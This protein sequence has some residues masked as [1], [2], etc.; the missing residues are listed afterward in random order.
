[1]QPS[2]QTEL[3]G[4]LATLCQYESM[5]GPYHPQTLCLLTQ[6]AGAYFEVGEFDFA[7]PLL[8]RAVR[9]TGR[10]LGYSHD[11]R[12]RAIADLRDLATAQGDYDRAEA[13]Q[14]EL[15]RLAPHTM[16]VQ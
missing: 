11:L 7:Q 4:M 12:M 14:A 13:L 10:Y 2:G 6:V 8:E 15:R 5:L 3:P 1:M 16:V 9:D